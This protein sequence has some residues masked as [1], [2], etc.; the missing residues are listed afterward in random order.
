[1][2]GPDTIA[3]RAARV[4]LVDAAGRVLL[5]RGFDPARPHHRYWF[6]VGG[7]LEPRE[8][9]ADG[10][11]RE[12]LEETGLRVPAQALGEPVWREV[13]EFPFDGRWYRQEQDFYLLRVPSWEV[14]VSGHNE[15]E[16]ASV[17]GYRWWSRD[18]LRGTD[19]RFYPPELPD[20]LDRLL[21][22]G[23]SAC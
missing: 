1:M 17:D 9:A 20:L 2:T 12:L 4:L 23:G 21:G 22:D 6:T 11:A 13:S 19:Q 3:R 18:E 7:G 5:L 10:A 16:R 8:S 15:L 14:D